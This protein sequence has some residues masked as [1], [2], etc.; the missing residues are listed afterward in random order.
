MGN[1]IATD[2]VITGAPE[3]VSTSDLIGLSLAA[4]REVRRSGKGSAVQRSKLRE[5]FEAFHAALE[6]GLSR[7]A[8]A[9]AAKAAS[10][11]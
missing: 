5:F 7:D 11:L 6:N 4:A 8:A 10:G 2:D 9:V 3:L 1:V